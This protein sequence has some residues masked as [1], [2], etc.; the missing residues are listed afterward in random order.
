MK[1]IVLQARRCGTPSTAHSARKVT[2]VPQLVLRALS[3]KT[4]LRDSERGQT[5]A[6]YGVVLASLVLGVV[7]ALLVFSGAILSAFETVN[8]T[9]SEILK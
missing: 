7:A 8:D 6:E 1:L 4:D 5:M 3:M 2:E 9:V